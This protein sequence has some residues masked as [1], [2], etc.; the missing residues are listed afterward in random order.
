MQGRVVVAGPNSD[1]GGHN[2]VIVITLY[3]KLMRIY[4]SVFVKGPYIAY[5]PELLVGNQM[6]IVCKFTH[7]LQDK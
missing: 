6:Q 5:E 1:G 4:W 2:A 7:Y 3:R